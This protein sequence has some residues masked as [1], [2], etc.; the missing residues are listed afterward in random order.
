MDRV[1]DD[2]LFERRWE[3]VGP[4]LNAT[5]FD[6]KTYLTINAAMHDAS[7]AA[8]FLSSFMFFSPSQYLFV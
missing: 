8:W 5:E 4:V 7:I 2:P 1:L 6:I 3:G